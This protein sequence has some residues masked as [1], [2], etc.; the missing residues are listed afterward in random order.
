MKTI[1]VYSFNELSESSKQKAIKDYFN[2]N[3][4]NYD[5]DCFKDDIENQ[6]SE[7]KIELKD[8]TYSL[9][10]SQGDGLSFTSEFDVK[11]Y[12]DLCFTELSEKRKS[13]LADLIHTIESSKNNGHYCYASKNDVEIIVNYNDL[14]TNKH[15][16]IYNYINKLELYIQDLYISL[17]KDFENQGYKE[18]EEQSSKEYISE[19]LI[20][21]EYEFLENGTKI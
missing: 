18:I 20:I 6:L 16:N 13:I 7:L 4:F 12:I 1:N 19:T 3:S 15:C 2:S 9:S 14:D 10:Y 8:L 21:N 5:L 17:C 11:H